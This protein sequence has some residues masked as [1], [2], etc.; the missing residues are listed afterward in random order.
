M[1]FCLPGAGL[2]GALHSLQGLKSVVRRVK[3]SGD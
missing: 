3:P 2:V 1:Y